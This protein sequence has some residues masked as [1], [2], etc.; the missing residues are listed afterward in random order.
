MDGVL[1]TFVLALTA[2][3]ALL[4]IDVSEVSVNGDSLEL[5]DLHT[6]LAGDATYAAGLAG[7]GAFVFVVA[8]HH[9]ATVLQALQ[10]NLDDAS[11]TSLG[12]STAGG[13]LHFIDFG[14]TRFGIHADSVELAGCHAV[15]T[16]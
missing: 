5:A 6:L 15:A 9:D 10:T 1:R 14:Q 8:E 7:L 4:G 2:E 13:T 12:A 3:F 16:P 11:R